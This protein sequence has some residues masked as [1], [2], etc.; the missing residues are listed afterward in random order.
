MPIAR[1]S[2]EDIFYAVRGQGLPVVFMHGAGG[3]HLIWNGQ[4]AA[5]APLVH[6]CA[7][8]LPGHG[9]STGPSRETVDEYA[10]AVCEWMDAVAL[11]NA[12]FVGTSMGGAIAQTLAL[13]HPKRVRAIALVGTGARLRVRPDFLDGLL[14][15]FEATAHQ[16][17]EMGFAQGASGYLKGLNEE[18]VIRCGAETVHDDFGACD[19]FDVRS[20]VGEIQCPTLVIVGR[21]DRMTPVKYSEWLAA[22]IP[23]AELRIIE[24]AGHMV[25]LERP[26][27]VSTAL[28]NWL[29]RL[30]E[31]PSTS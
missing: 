2:N 10:E 27:E 5:L 25:M 28:A 1:L 12:V 16:I 6:A 8:D 3:S 18:G 29:F 11:P 15:D 17:T 26:A 4:L 14:V 22:N 13:D 19:I 9:R 20:R 30:P 7:L 24:G 21:E 23:G 31:L